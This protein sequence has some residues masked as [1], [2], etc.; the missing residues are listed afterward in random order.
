MQQIGGATEI[1]QR[2]PQAPSL[3]PA[4]TSTPPTRETAPATGSIAVS[5]L[6]RRRASPRRRAYGRKLGLVVFAT[7]SGTL[8]FSLLTDG[9][10]QTRA[11]TTFLPES[12]RVLYWMGLRIE[13]VSLS[14]QRFTPDADVFEAVDLPN[15]GS[16]L[17]LDATA[18]RTRIEALPWVASATINRVFPAAIEVRITERRATALWLHDNREYLIDASGRV[19]S[20]LKPGTQTGLPRVSGDG[21]ETQAQALLDLVIRFPRIA[22]RFEMAERVG[23]RR[24]TLHLKHGVTIHL[25]ADREAVA[26]GALSSPDDLGR[27]LAAHDVIIDMRTRGRITVRPSPQNAGAPTTSPTQS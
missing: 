22:E 1:P 11:A 5:R 9:G 8:A 15:A 7:L 6:P 26:F 23:G 4:A 3:D 27:L 16:L 14:G 12:E 21:A 18:T 10:R 25:G 20:A 24:W 2:V 13:Q 17:T 19:L